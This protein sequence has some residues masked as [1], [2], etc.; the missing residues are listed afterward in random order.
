[1]LLAQFLRDPVDDFLIEEVNAWKLILF[2]WL[3]TF[4]VAVEVLRMA[5]IWLLKLWTS[6]AVELHGEHARGW[7]VS[8]R[9]HQARMS[10]VENTIWAWSSQ[11]LRLWPWRRLLS[12]HWRWSILI[13]MRENSRMWLLRVIVKRLPILRIRMHIEAKRRPSSTMTLSMIELLVG[14]TAVLH[15]RSVIWLWR[16]IPR[17][18]YLSHV[19][20]AHRKSTLRWHVMLWLLLCVAWVQAWLLMQRCL[21]V[22]WARRRVAW[23]LIPTAWL[24]RVA[25]GIGLN[26]VRNRVSTG[27]TSWRLF[28]LLI[29]I[30]MIIFGLAHRL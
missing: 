26:M 7:S 3:G 13:A 24:S 6:L 20:L 22:L 27:V 19:S 12:M 17:H 25:L 10:V 9:R 29:F 1:M 16:I 28:L 15:L 21:H 2:F 18:I 14:C 30:K 23:L 5:N 4:V 11:H 8:R